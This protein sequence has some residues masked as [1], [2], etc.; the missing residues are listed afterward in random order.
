MTKQHSPR[1]LEIVNDAR[2]RISETDAA[3]VSERIRRGEPFHLL[4]VREASE[5]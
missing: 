4:D 5:W 3:A 2:R 1:F